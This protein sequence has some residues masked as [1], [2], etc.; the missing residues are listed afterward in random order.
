[1]ASKALATAFVN[2]VPGTQDFEASLKSQLGGKTAAI[3]ATA[4]QQL[5]GGLKSRFSA[6][7][8]GIAA[9]LTAA[10]SVYAAG[11]FL[12]GAIQKA[13]DLGEQGAA[14]GQVFG[15]GADAIKAFADGAAT[16]LG[17][18]S[19]QILEA[20][21]SFGI[22]GKAAGLGDSANADFSQNLVRLATDLASFNNTSVDDAMLALQS[23]L[24]GEAEPL[25]Q[26]GVLLDDATLRAQALKMGIVDSTKTALTPQQKVLAANAAIFEQTATQQ[27]DFARTSG[28]LANQ[29]RILTASWENAQTVLG[30]AL[31]P[32]MAGLVEVL[33]TNVIPAIKTFFEDFKAGKTPLNDIITGVQNFVGFVS[34][35]WTWIS[36]LGAAII[37]A[38]AA[39]KLLTGAFTVYTAIQKGLA[40]AQTVMAASQALQSGATISATVAQWGFNAALLANPITWVVVGIA[41]LVAGLV[42][43][44][45]QTEV[46]KEAWAAFTGFLTEAWANFTTW[47]GEAWTNITTFFSEAIANVVGFVQEHW[48]LILSFLIGPIGLAIQWIVEHWSEIVSFFSTSWNNIVSFFQTA[49]SN[50]GNAVSTGVTNVVNFF[51]ELPGNIMKAIGN[52]GTMLVETGRNMIQGLLDGAGSLLGSI[53]SFFLSKLPGWIVEPFKA[54]LGIHSPSRVFIQFGKNIGQGLIKGL[55]GSESGIKTQM[56][57]TSD[58][59]K[60]Q[61][62]DGKL[63]ASAKKAALALIASSQ[64]AL[65]AVAKQHEK[66]VKKLEKAQDNLNDKLAEKAAYV[67][68]IADKFGSAL[69]I[70]D[71]TSAGDAVA[72][73]QARIEKNKELLAVLNDLKTMGLSNDLYKQVLESGNLDFARSIQ[74]GGAATIAQLNGLAEEANKTA[75]ELGSTAGSVLF[76]QGIQVAQGI[77]D[78]LKEKKKDLED[79]MKSLAEAFKRQLSNIIANDV[80][81]P[82]GGGGGGSSTTALTGS[83]GT[84]ASNDAHRAAGVGGY[85]QVNTNTLAG[86]LAASGIPMMA[87][88]GFVSRPTQAIIGE[89]GPEVV[90]PLRDFERMMGLDGTKGAQVLNY[91]AAPNQSLDSEAALFNAIKRAKV[92]AKW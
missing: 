77:V 63:S 71:A 21:K 14:V 29:Q 67:S 20:S 65:T 75:L 16:S 86:I 59:I 92:V 79:E 4:G 53:G 19:V 80:V 51:R 37:G 11:N 2:I 5:G 18:S 73:L 55:T 74:A 52:L 22:Y 1:M 50:I 60:K 23:G 8:R 35:N 42:W 91:Y 68:N 82:A 66:V 10:F 88:G 3:G 85:T 89:A 56:K 70:Q 76:D 32:A 9:P 17:Q 45:T 54:A 15:K 78:G 7:I 46:G 61:F 27:G 34:A 84:V 49:L 6:A 47:I 28:G 40:F 12:N 58:W 87:A 26:F 69:D 83:Q 13:S 36:T 62:D 25:R 39:V 72:Q 41:A 44:F 30:E 48:G 38:V 64:K 33:N 90:T 31:L 57:K 81:A 43:F 24:R